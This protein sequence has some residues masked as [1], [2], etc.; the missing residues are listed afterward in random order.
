MNQK[1]YNIH[2]II[3][4]RILR[5]SEYGLRDLINLKFSFF[6]VNEKI[7][8]PDITLNI[9]KFVPSNE[10]CYL[11]DH[12]YHVK[13]DYFYCKDAEGKAE[14][15]MEILGFRKEETII[16]FNGK[17]S[18]FQSFMNPDFLAQNLL[19][20]I[21]EYKLNRTKLNKKEMKETFDYFDLNTTESSN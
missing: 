7:D 8:N 6:E 17:I 3:K 9:G 4:F 12:K 14:W 5:D 16:N 10:D 13:D 19:L 15:E 2:N 21:I 1:N 20:R 18:G 11:V